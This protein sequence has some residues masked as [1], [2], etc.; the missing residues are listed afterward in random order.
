MQKN[1]SQLM[2]DFLIDIGPAQL[3]NGLYQLLDDSESPIGSAGIMFNSVISDRGGISPRPGTQLLGTYD[4]SNFPLDGVYNYKKSG[5]E[6][7]VPVKASNGILK[8]FHPDLLDWFTLQ[9]GYTPNNEFGFK[10]SLVNTE[11]DDYLYFCNRMEN[12]SRWSGAA[13]VTVGS[14]AS[15]ATV[16]TVSSIL[17]DPVYASGSANRPGDYTGATSASSNQPAISVA[18]VPAWANNQWVGATLTMT[19]GASSGMNRSITSNFFDQLN[20]TAALSVGLGDTFTLTFPAA[21]TTFMVDDTK[22]WAP[23]QWINFYVVFTSGT[24]SG[25]VRLITDNKTNSLTFNALAGIPA[26]GDTYQIQL[27]KFPNTG[28]LIIG[29]IKVNYYS[30][31]SSTSFSIV[32]PGVIL[33]TNSPVTI[34]PT[35]YPQN[36]KGNR[37]E[38]NYTRMIV[39]NVRSGLARDAAGN[40]TGSQSS[41]SYYYAKGGTGKTADPTNFTFAATRTPGD[42]GIES[43]PYGGHD[44]TDIANQEN[45]FYIFKKNYIEGDNFTQDGNDLPA[46]TQLKTQLGSLHKVVK[47]KDDIYFVTPDNQITSIGRIKF[48]DTEPRSFNLGIVIKRLL[49]KFDFNKTHGGE[50]KNRLFFACKSKP[51]NNYNDQ[52]IVFNQETKTFEGIWQIGTSGLFEYQG[53]FYY[54]EAAG[55]NVWK[56]FTGYNDVRDDAHQFGITSQWRSNRFHISRKQRGVANSKFDNLGINV[57]G[58]EGFILDGT[59]LTFSIFS[60]YNTDPSFTFNFGNTDS[61]KQFVSN[62]SLDDF[63]GANPLGLSPLGM[64]SDADGDG[65][66]HFAFII[67]MPFIYANYL[68][69]QLFCSGKNQFYDVTRMAANVYKSGTRPYSIIKTN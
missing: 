14:T 46:R 58:V 15:N 48:V 64:V 55:S 34:V 33:P 4:S 19:S 68:S 43:V 6:Q 62:L 69:F 1:V 54:G 66:R 44:I 41:G 35:E 26:N 16:L 47:G 40:V 39:G 29:S 38:L 31:L 13:T 51:T 45:T 42:G 21:S 12:Y 8:Y 27:S 25:Q 32:T 36:P 20:F 28:Q 65:L 56:M 23:S 11:N 2:N 3:Q 49:D 63:L 24:Y 59:E 52:L 5:E 10:E 22:N 9:T 57:F 37:L 53:E 17:K 7:E 18:S 60:D 50:F 67:Y 30:I 61:D